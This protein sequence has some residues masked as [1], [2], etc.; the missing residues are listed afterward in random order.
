MT[1]HLYCQNLMVKF[2]M[3][4]FPLMEYICP[5]DKIKAMSFEI[6]SQI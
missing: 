5:E 2:V 1:V 3:A 4:I 6:Q